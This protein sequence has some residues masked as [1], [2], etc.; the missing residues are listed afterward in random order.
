MKDLHFQGG[1]SEALVRAAAASIRRS[2]RAQ[3]DATRGCRNL[4]WAL[5]VELSRAETLTGREE[6][7]A[8]CAFAR[9]ELERAVRGGGLRVEANGGGCRTSMK[10][11]ER[12]TARCVEGACPGGE[13]LRCESGA[14]ARRCAGGCAPAPGAASMVCDGRCDGTC[15]A[16]RCSPDV[17][18]GRVECHGHCDGACLGALSP[19]GLCDG[20]CVGSCDLLRDRGVVCVGRCQG[21]C[22]GGCLPYSGLPARCSGVCASPAGEIECAG[23]LVGGCTSGLAGSSCAVDCAIVAGGEADCAPTPVTVLAAPT[24]GHVRD[25]LAQHLPVILAA[26]SRAALGAGRG[27][28]LGER[29][30]RAPLKPGCERT[31][32]ADAFRSDDIDRDV[33]DATAAFANLAGVP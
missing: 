24:S 33:L 2:E 21:Q 20:T 11:H 15:S 17:R 5:G 6:L 27:T 22:A 23:P 18:G 26:R 31:Y 14:S 1:A 32:A 4:A 7:F 10:A 12:C 28:A 13:P 29:V 8:T 30:V 9:G 25:A 19:E 16:A 3:E